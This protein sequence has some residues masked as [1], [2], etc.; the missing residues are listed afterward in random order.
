L[1]LCKEKKDESKERRKEENKEEKT[2][3]KKSKLTTGWIYLSSELE[4]VEENSTR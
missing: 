4:W 2:G 1:K 3:K